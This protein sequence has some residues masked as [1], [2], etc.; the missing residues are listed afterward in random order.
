MVITER[1]PQ[2]EKGEWSSAVPVECIGQL[3]GEARWDALR[4]CV[5]RSHVDVFVHHNWCNTNLLWDIL[6]LKCLG[7]KVVLNVHGL[8]AHF[9]YANNGTR[10]EWND[11]GK[12]AA[13][14]MVSSLCD[15]VVCETHV[16]KRFFGFFNERTY[17]IPNVLEERYRMEAPGDGV[18]RS[19]RANTVLWVGRFDDLKRPD[20]AVRVIAKVKRTIPDARLL[21]VGES[22][23]G[24]IE[25]DLEA[26]IR[27]LGLEDSVC[28][29]GFA[30]PMRYYDEAAVLVSTTEIEGFCMV[31]YEA[32]AR[33]LPIVSY[34]MPYLP[35]A[36]CKGIVWVDQGDAEAAAEEVV[37]LLG[38]ESAWQS[39]S[40]E[41][42]E[43]AE[44]G[45]RDIYEDTWTGMLADISHD[46]SGRVADC[47]SA[48]NNAWV[49]CRG[50]EASLWRLY[51]DHFMRGQ[52]Q[53]AASMERKDARI[54]EIE[55]Q[56]ERLREEV[57]E[58]EHSISYRLGRAILALPRA[59]RDLLRR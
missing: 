14:P 45:L 21:I 9:A 1:Q 15:A 57:A 39:A 58:Y 4:R 11:G 19:K 32:C 8:F 2:R 3:S 49:E 16:N 29:E 22:G 59:M 41:V 24:G 26:Q 44:S 53:V 23:W 13:V 17:A 37:R 52:E 46:G 36:E 43:F 20:E 28:L 27:D 25:R 54:F 50:D 12:F 34:D 51:L 42:L 7:V 35:F 5:Q 6:L 40:R 31:L 18:E 56:I 33:G 55:S 47:A 10:G 48:P 30:D 38:D